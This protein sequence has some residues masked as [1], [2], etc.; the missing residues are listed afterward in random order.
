[1]VK[2]KEKIRKFLTIFLK[3]QLDPTKTLISHYQR[4]GFSFLGFEVKMWSPK[5]VKISKTLLK[6]NSG[7]IRTKR[8]DNSRKVTIRPDKNRILKNLILKGICKKDG[9]PIG[10]RHWAILEEKTI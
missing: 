3:L 1:M 6:T 7:F 4:D 5:Q 8:R 9:Y 2:A 10:V